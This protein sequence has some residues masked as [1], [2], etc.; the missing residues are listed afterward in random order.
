[1]TVTMMRMTTL[2]S[3]NSSSKSKGLPKG[4]ARACSSSSSSPS[5]S[6]SQSSSSSFQR[7]RRLLAR[8]LP[9][10]GLS[11]VVAVAATTLV[12]PAK[13][14]LAFG[15]GIPGYDVNE[16]AR[17]RA[18]DKQ[19]QEI[20]AQNARAKEYQQKLEQG[21][22]VSIALPGTTKEDGDV[23]QPPPCWPRPSCD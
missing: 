3:S 1:M 12:V 2:T 15:N 18:S 16:E 13:P 17:S 22:S 20:D 10:S 7:R 19:K 9:V 6:S 11:M 5:P 23:P 14:A 21:E 4:Y 8:L